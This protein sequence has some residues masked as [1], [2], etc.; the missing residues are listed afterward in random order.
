MNFARETW[1]PVIRGIYDQNFAI[2]QFGGFVSLCPLVTKAYQVVGGNSRMV[3]LLLQNSAANVSL[4]TKGF[5]FIKKNKKIK[6]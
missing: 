1:E 3:Q 2:S 5:F 4:N 6:K